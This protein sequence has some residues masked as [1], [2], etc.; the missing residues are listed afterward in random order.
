MDIS[1]RTP[2]TRSAFD[3]PNRN[4]LGN[5]PYIESHRGCNKEEPENTLAAFR[6]SIEYECDSIELDIWLSKDNIPMVI[7]CTEEGDIGETTNGEGKIN[8]LT[9]FELNTFKT[10]NSESIPTLEAALR[11]CKDKVFVN[12]E[13]KD[14]NFETCL[15]IV[16][17]IV[18]DLDMKRQIAISSFKHEY[19]EIINKLD[20]NI[21]FGFLYD[22]YQFD[23]VFDKPFSTLNIWQGNINAEVVLKAHEANMGIQVWFK[24]DDEETSEVYEHLFTCGVDVICSNFP[25]RAI[26]SR[27]LFYQ[28]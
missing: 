15:S 1:S 10:H 24:M 28:S 6:K 22:D 2:P 7:H 18:T 26:E 3:A 9:Y 5:K 16:L 20:N 4:R 14:S 12:I 13:I 27:D 23:Y 19:W 25:D 21:E 8:N 17:G 11:L